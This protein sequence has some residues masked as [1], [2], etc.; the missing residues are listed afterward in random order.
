MDG[1]LDYANYHWGRILNS[2]N[3]IQTHAIFVK[4]ENNFL[5]MTKW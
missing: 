1:R 3:A 4:Q 5:E 2:N